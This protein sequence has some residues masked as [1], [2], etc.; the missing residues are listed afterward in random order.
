VTELE[1]AGLTANSA[2]GFLAALGALAGVRRAFP[3]ARLHWSADFWP[4]AILSG[5]DPYVVVDKL[6]VDRDERL[7]GPVLNYP[8]DR[9]YDTLKCTVDELGEWARRVAGLPDDDPD[10]DMWSALVVEGG[11][12]NNNKAKP[13]HFDFS[14]GQVKFLK[15]VREICFS[16]DSAALSEALFGP[17][18]YEGEL[19]TLRFEKEG[20]RIQA[21]RGVPPADEPLN[22]V[23]GA[24]W[25]AFRGLV[26]Y[27]LSVRRGRGRARVITPACDADWNRGWFRWPVWAEPLAYWAVAALVTDPR[28]VGESVGVRVHTPDALRAWGVRSVWASAMVRSG[29]GYGSFGPAKQIARA[30]PSSYRS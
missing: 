21:L 26:F 15:V 5:V 27:P 17:W 23:P 9:P 28:V 7:Q 8:P 16:L 13:T 24:D 22:G 29:Q 4:H 12:D 19:S 10:L 18:L 25:L 2:H 11:L 30:M 3:D 20:E 6:L 1:L 14:A